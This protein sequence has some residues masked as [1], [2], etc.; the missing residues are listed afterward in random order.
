MN[1]QH[2]CIVSMHSI[3]TQY[4][5]TVSVHNIITKYVCCVCVCFVWLC[6]YYCYF[7]F[8]SFLLLFFKL[9]PETGQKFALTLCRGERQCVRV[10]GACPI[11]SVHAYGQVQFRYNLDLCEA[12]LRY[13]MY[14]CIVSIHSIS[15][16]HQCIVSV[17]N[18]STQYQYTVSIHSINTQCQYTVSVH[19][20]SCLL[21]TSPSPRD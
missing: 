13:G 3:S 5:Y 1:T 18:I 12:P 10:W 2:Q 15:T 19:S 9:K 21:Y 11:Y 8:V 6:Y 7:V 14:Q 16:Q 20:T 4:Q 17:H